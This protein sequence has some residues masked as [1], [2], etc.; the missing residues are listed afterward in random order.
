MLIFQQH[1][2]STNLR[3]DATQRQGYMLGTV[4]LPQHFSY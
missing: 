3:R 2:D 4:K 1:D